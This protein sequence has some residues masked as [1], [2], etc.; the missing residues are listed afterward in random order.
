MQL[1]AEALQT[2]IKLDTAADSAPRLSSS[3]SALLSRET[4][5]KL[6]LLCAFNPHFL[7]LLFA[8]VV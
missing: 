3:L 7:L 4:R 6:Q 5:A 8:L 1:N 2:G